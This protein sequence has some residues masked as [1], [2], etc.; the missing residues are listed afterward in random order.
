M[1]R[2]FKKF[3]GACFSAVKKGLGRSCFVRVPPAQRARSQSSAPDAHH[4][5]VHLR[6]TSA[7]TTR[8]SLCR[9]TGSGTQ[10]QTSLMWM[11]FL[12]NRRPPRARLM[13]TSRSALWPWAARAGPSAFSQ[14]L[15]PAD[16]RSERRRSGSNPRRGR[17][18]LLN[19]SV[20]FVARDVA[21]GEVAF[22]PCVCHS[23]RDGRD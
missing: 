22:N 21:Q 7:S 11:T 15:C 23:A 12:Q 13:P 18:V 3:F 9:P 17:C 1:G 8:T 2:S 4:V 14:A 10:E 19:F 6:R 20:L 16:P 5:C